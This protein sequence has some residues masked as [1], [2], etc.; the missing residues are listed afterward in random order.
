MMAD[1]GAL[2]ELR[3]QQWPAR[4]NDKTYGKKKAPNV[5]SRAMHFDL[6]GG[7]DENNVLP[8][9]MDLHTEQKIMDDMKK[10]TLSD[11]ARG[12]PV[13][14]KPPVTEPTPSNKK[15]PTEHNPRLRGRRKPISQRKMAVSPGGYQLQ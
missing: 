10:L 13:P 12:A 4:R 5:E 15:K 1:F 11:D 2:S 9:T 7:S 3:N 6:Y 8:S 14:Q